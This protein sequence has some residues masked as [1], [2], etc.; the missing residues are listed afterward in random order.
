[1]IA[2]VHGPPGNKAPV[3]RWALS[4]KRPFRWKDADNGTA[5]VGV[6]LF[7]F[8]KGEAHGCELLGEAQLSAG[9]ARTEVLRH[10]RM[11]ARQ[12]DTTAKA[13]A[14]DMTRLVL[15]RERTAKIVRI[16]CSRQN[17]LNASDA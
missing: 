7:G 2:D 10:H 11:L 4:Y 1:M 14:K 6:S 13:V 5:V 15:R 12:V 17:P 3:A 16:R 8:A 9:D